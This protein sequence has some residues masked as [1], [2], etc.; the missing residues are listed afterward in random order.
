M[1]KKIALVSSAL[2]AA[3]LV[4][5]AFS[6]EKANVII[7]FND[8][9]GYQD[10]GCYGSPNISTPRIDQLAKE[11]M[12]YT[13]FYVASSVSSAS[14]A[15]LLT[16]CYPQRVGVFGVIGAGANSGLN[17]EHTTI[18][19][20]LKS[21]GYVT[22][23]VGKWHLGDMQKFLPTNQG[24]DSYW[25]IPYSNDMFPSR[26]TKYATNCLWRNG[27]SEDSLKRVF[28]ALAPDNIRPMSV[29]ENVPLLR[30]LECIEYPVDQSNITKRYADEA[31]K[32]IESSVKEKKP[33]FLY[34][35]N[36]MPHTPLYASPQFKGK[37]KRGLYGDVIEEIDYNIGRI[38]DQLKALNV[39]ENT[40]VIYSSDNGPWLPKGDDSGSAL[41]L[42]EGKFSS[43]EGGMR[44]PFI[45]RWPKKIPAGRVCT[46]LAAS[47]DIL[48]TLTSIV[49]AKLP[50]AEID[51]TNIIGLW[52][53]KK[54]VKSP[55]N[56]YFM[57]Y[58]GEA[59]RWGD[60]KYHKNK[61]FS[62]P[63]MLKEETPALYNL[64]DDIG[65]TKN[66]ID[67]HPEIATRLASALDSH[68]KRISK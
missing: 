1:N 13:D 28:A 68:L 5:K 23:A 20:V 35:A 16:G 59:V 41:P 26:H 49:G 34:L 29:K 45:V 9:Q 42:F 7:I 21:A 33:F 60:W 67:Q 18:A 55:R 27:F 3:P 48:P 65:E 61:Y 11:G 37:S 63:K 66:L 14:R 10:L 8:D 22:A 53:D 64:K 12:R 40:I 54:K 17:S 44:V 2:L 4:F 58:N 43:F 52:K 57:V 19:E 39:D 6:T 51:G 30:N 15:A 25:G 50:Q 46:E 38:M 62:V 32:F 31:I 56:Y 24:F 47:I 36:S